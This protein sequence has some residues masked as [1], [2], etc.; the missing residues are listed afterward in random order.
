[1]RISFMTFSFL[2]IFSPN[3]KLTGT[4]FFSASGGARVRRLTSPASVVL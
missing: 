2:F 3:E 1:M 4:R